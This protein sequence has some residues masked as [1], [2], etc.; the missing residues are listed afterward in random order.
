MPRMMARFR[1]PSIVADDLV[2]RRSD[3]RPVF[4]RKNPDGV[5]Q[6]STIDREYFCNRQ[7]KVAM[8]GNFNERSDGFDWIHMGTQRNHYGRTGVSDDMV[9]LDGKEER[10]VVALGTGVRKDL[11]L[12]HVL[13]PFEL[14]ARQTGSSN[15][16]TIALQG[17][18]IAREPGPVF[19]GHREP[20][21]RFL[22]M[23]RQI[24][25]TLVGFQSIKQ[26]LAD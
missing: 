9:V 21:Q 22:S 14:F 19:K 20:G 5:S 2:K 23:G 16:F 3:L 24:D 10:N 17:F 13:D 7:Y 12:S 18:M 6:T 8:A 1:S 11:V 15:G 4:Q 26:G 25:L